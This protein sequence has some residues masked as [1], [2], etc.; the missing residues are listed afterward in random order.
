ML[1]RSLLLH[2]PPLLHFLPLSSR[3]TSSAFT[4]SFEEEEFLHLTVNPKVNF[5]DSGAHTNTS[6]GMWRHAKAFSHTQQR[7]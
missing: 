1:R 3:A 6:E 2:S 4:F 7:T 5:V